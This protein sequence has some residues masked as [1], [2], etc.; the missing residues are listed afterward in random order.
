VRIGALTLGDEFRQTVRLTADDEI[1][2]SAP[3]STSF[4]TSSLGAIPFRI[5]RSHERCA[6][7]TASVWHAD[8]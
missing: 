8:R 3:R 7:Q 1:L 2:G 5:V 4:T 6:A